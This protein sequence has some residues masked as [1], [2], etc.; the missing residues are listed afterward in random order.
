MSHDDVVPFCACAWSCSHRRGGGEFYSLCN[1]DGHLPLLSETT[2]EERNR[3]HHGVLL[4]W[5]GDCR[6]EGSLI[7]TLRSSQKGFCIF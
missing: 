4:G 2:E 1:R 5:E 3:F 7:D 6:S